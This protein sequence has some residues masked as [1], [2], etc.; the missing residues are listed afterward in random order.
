MLL[1]FRVKP[2]C[3][4]KPKC[5]LSLSYDAWLGALLTELVRHNACAGVACDESVLL[6]KLASLLC[7]H[8]GATPKEAAAV[9][10][11]TP[12]L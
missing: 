4:L 6:P 12:E 11:P 1:T 5:G 3:V 10:T 7:D 8:F 9:S 2:K